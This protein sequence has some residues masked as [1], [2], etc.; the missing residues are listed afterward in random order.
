MKRPLIRS[1]LIAAA[2][3]AALLVVGGIAYATIPDSAGV[4]HACYQKS[5][6]TIR[7]IDASVTN[8]SSKETSLGWNV[9]G[10]PG[11]PGPQGLP[12]ATGPSGSQYVW[13]G[14][15]YTG[16]APQA[17]G[18]V[19]T[20]SFSAPTGGFAVVTAHFG[21]RVRNTPNTDCHV[22]SQLASA[23]SVLTDQRPGPTDAPGYIDEWINGNL[24]TEDGSGT[25]LE[26]NESVSRVFPV[27]AGLNTV[28]LNGAYNG[29]DG[30]NCDAV[31]WGPINITALFAQQN[32]AATLTAP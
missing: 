31:G 20:F 14:W 17:D 16:D 9:Q 27:S 23:P 28:Y 13:T 21:V 3:A 2:A 11:A 25:F 6:G 22:Q 30:P 7:V 29:Y 19:A 18:H 24:P 15:V 1:A 5:G 10:Q 26:L 32:P 12:G 4:I 8:C